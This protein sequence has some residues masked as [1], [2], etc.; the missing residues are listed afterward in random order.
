MAGFAWRTYYDGGVQLPNAD[1]SL[2]KGLKRSFLNGNGPLRFIC[3]TNE[4]YLYCGTL[5]SLSLSMENYARPTISKATADIRSHVRLCWAVNR[6]YY[7]FCF[8]FTIF[9]E[10]VE[11]IG[12][13]KACDTPYTLL[14]IY[15]QLRHWTSTNPE[16]RP[17]NV[18][19]S[20]TRE[21][22]EKL[23]FVKWYRRC[24]SCDNEKHCITY[25]ALDFGVGEFSKS[26]ANGSYES[27]T[28]YFCRGPRRWRNC[29]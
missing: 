15:W 1:H 28:A 11:S 7:V 20:N 16:R 12:C 3:D 22:P 23:F 13:S 6:N 14:R 24:D 19:F 4:A 26:I 25:S 10:C 29:P 2:G 5:S 18:G 21:Q 27:F 17:S 8:V 9:L